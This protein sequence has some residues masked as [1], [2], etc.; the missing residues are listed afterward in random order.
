M[1]SLLLP[2]QRNALARNTLWMLLGEGLRLPIQAGYFII[3]AHSLGPE[4]YG[5][6]AAVTALVA[7]VAP[8]VGIGCDKLVVKNVAR[9]SLLLDECVGNGILSIIAT[10]VGAAAIIL[11]IAHYL[12]PSSIAETVVLMV[13][14]S[15]LVCLR[16]IDLAASAFQSLERL[17]RTAM[18]NILVSALRLVGAALLGIVI[19]H[20]SALSW[21]AIYAVATAV[22]MSIS[23]LSLRTVVAS[24][25]VSLVRLRRELAEGLYFSGGQ[26]AQTIYNDVDKTMLAR[27]GSLDASG[28][29]AAAYRIIDVSF[30]PV[31]SLLFA[32]YPGFFQ[33]GKTSLG[34]AYSHARRL[35]PG[36]LLFSIVTCAV[37]IICA[38]VVPYILGSSYARTV[39][40]VR[41][42]SPLPLLK[43]A[44]YLLADALTGAGY[45][46]LRM[47]IQ[48]SVALFNVFV[49]LWIIPA[50]SWR[51]AAWSSLASDALL[52]VSLWVAITVLRQIKAHE[53]AIGLETVL[54]R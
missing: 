7:I 44:H 32:A 13:A 31:R 5:A 37:L 52:A 45:Q 2:Y 9:N 27:L 15:D 41:W 3:I 20:A 46:G 33:H 18:L 8:F 53:T 4:Q 16:L 1:R 43:T 25:K 12:L 28:L 17:N 34:A 50:Y 47:Y 11:S 10:G 39:E 21:S 54:S 48:I 42:L 19:H 35:L 49:N 22:A 40:A 30:V 26:S 29:Y 14:L 36:P 38:P 24:F 23:V 51:G 6:F